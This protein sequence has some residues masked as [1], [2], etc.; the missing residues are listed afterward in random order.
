MDNAFKAKF[1][2][3]PKKDEIPILIP[4]PI[5]YGINYFRLVVLTTKAEVAMWSLHHPKNG[6]VYLYDSMSIYS[7]YCLV[8]GEDGVHGNLISKGDLGYA[9]FE[10]YNYESI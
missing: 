9:I 2:R 3:K 10:K 5:D 6:E 8:F 4:D 1:G 7:L